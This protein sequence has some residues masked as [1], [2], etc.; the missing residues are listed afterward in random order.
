MPFPQS[1][2]SPSPGRRPPCPRAAP[3]M[4]MGM[5]MSLL[6]LTGVLPVRYF[7]ERMPAIISLVV[8]LPTEPV[9]PTTFRLRR[10]RPWRGNVSQGLPGISHHNG[11][12]VSVAAAAQHGGRSGMPGPPGINSWP[13]LRP[14]QGYKQLAGLQAPGVV[15]RPQ[16]SAPGHIGEPLYRRTNGRPAPVSFCS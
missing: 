10:I 3:R 6:W 2:S 4:A 7:R 12:K 15:T 8:L 14:L 9:T 5:P 1:D 16:K 11:G 13:S